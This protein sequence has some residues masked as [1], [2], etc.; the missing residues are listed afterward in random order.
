LP[1]SVTPGDTATVHI[2][3]VSAD[4]GIY[5]LTLQAAGGGISK[6]VDLALVLN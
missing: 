3:T 1:S 4:P 6:S 2:E 5:Y